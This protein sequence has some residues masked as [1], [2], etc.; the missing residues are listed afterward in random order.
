[1]SSVES[2]KHSEDIQKE[3]M[4][5]SYACSSLK[6]LSGGNA[7]FT[8]KGL[9]T[10]PLEDGTQEVVIKHGEAYVALMPDLEIPTSRCVRNCNLGVFQ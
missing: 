1:M 3:L 9:L 7:N 2:L 5:T 6:P 8:F 4:S 10:H